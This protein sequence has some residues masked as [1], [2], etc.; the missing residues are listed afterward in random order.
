MKKS[1]LKINALKRPSIAL[2]VDRP[3]WALANTANELIQHL[4]N[5]Y[6]FSIYYANQYENIAL[7]VQELRDFDLI[8]FLYRQ[9][10]FNLLDPWTINN[11]NSQGGNFSELI[12]QVVG[13]LLITT[14]VHDHLFL[15]EYEIRERDIL[16]SGLAIGYVVLSRRLFE[17]YKNIEL[18]PSPLRIN[19]NGVNLSIFQ[20]DNLERLTDTQREIIVGWAGNSQW[21]V[22]LLDGFDHKGLETIIKV[23]VDELRS[24]GIRVRGEYLDRDSSGCSFLD[25]PDYYKSIDI[26]LCASDVE[27]IPNPVMEAMACGLPV[28]STDVGI[29]PEV[30]GSL[31]SQYIVQREVNAFKAKIRKLVEHPQM[32]VA[33]SQEN[34]TS[35]QPWDWSEKT[36]GWDEFF[37]Q[38]LVSFRP[39][40]TTNLRW[41]SGYLDMRKQ[42]LRER[43]RLIQSRELEEASIKENARLVDENST[44]TNQ[45][46]ELMNENS[47]LV[48][49]GSRAHLRMHQAIG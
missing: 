26:Y 41:S 49:E 7:L 48:G 29:V 24:E 14:S 20:P 9:N 16:F 46:S 36:K 2:I 15:K 12:E 34:L 44:L 17:I 10:L 22:E 38:I 47:R 25:M 5:K 23:A 3:G 21:G 45:V 42:L 37:Q 13:N 19:Q 28:I 30:F 8:H 31:Q 35:I 1:P 39:G 43:V 4:G 32:R 6:K 40:K 11:F 18:Y 33:L 27:A